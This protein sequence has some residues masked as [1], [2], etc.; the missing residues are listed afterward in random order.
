M[1]WFQFESYTA[2]THQYTVV[3]LVPN[4]GYTDNTVGQSP[5]ICCSLTDYGAIE[6]IDRGG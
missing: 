4:S 3:L 5:P 6:V 1:S 2:H